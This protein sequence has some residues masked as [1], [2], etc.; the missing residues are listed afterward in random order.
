MLRIGSGIFSAILPINARSIFIIRPFNPGFSSV[1]SFSS[2]FGFSPGFFSSAFVGSTFSAGGALG[3]G[4]AFF[5]LPS[6]CG[7]LRFFPLALFRF[8][9]FSVDLSFSSDG[10]LGS[11]SS[12]AFS[13]SL[14]GMG[15]ETELG[16]GAGIDPELGSGTGA[17]TGSSIGVNSWIGGADSGDFCSKIIAGALSSSEPC[18][19][20]SSYT[21]TPIISMTS[22]SRKKPRASPSGF[23]GVA[24]EEGRFARLTTSLIFRPE[25]SCTTGGSL[26]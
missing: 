5:F 7:F 13:V 4:G 14:S 1:S 15:L 24:T 18:P 16:S 21:S 19:L 11:V 20:V 3:S 17:G 6:P 25:T 2:D 12:G 9:G 10:S 8:T 22:S 23:I 26:K